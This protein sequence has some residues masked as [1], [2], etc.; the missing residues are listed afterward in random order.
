MT[1]QNTARPSDDVA[2]VDGQKYDDPNEDTTGLA[3]KMAVHHAARA[4]AYHAILND[5][6]ITARSEVS[7]EAASLLPLETEL[8]TVWAALAGG[9]SGFE[10]KSAPDH[11]EMAASI[12]FYLTN[13]DDMS[14]M[15]AWVLDWAGIPETRIKAYTPESKKPRI[16]VLCGSTRFR[17]EFR[18]VNEDLTKLK[19][20]V[21]A[22]AVFADDG[23][24]I[25]DELKAELGELH[26]HKIDLADEVY[27]INPG[28]YIGE[29]TAREIAYAEKAGKRIFYPY[30]PLTF[31]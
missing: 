16:A 2:S 26:L 25:S 12:A 1:E 22:P 21:V 23:D 31:A 6:D 10:G 4:T 20:I 11:D 9:W 27:V 5:P 15:S 17:E 24:E 19:M 14:A 8:A 13:R 30:S 29:S 28:G 7:R 3:K 18:K